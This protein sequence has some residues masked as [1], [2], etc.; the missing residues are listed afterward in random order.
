MFRLSFVF[1]AL[2][3]FALPGAI[4]VEAA[5]GP[6]GV[7]MGQKGDELVFDDD[8]GDGYYVLRSVPRPHSHFESYIVMY[9]EGTG[10][11][12]FRAV[13]IDVATGADGTALKA[14]YE[15]IAGLVSRAY[16]NYDHYEHLADGSSL[17][18]DDNYMKAMAHGEML[19]QASW[20]E[21]SK[22]EL[23]NDITE[24]LLWGKA[25]D[26]ETGYVLLQYR[27]AN[28]AEC[29]DS[30]EAENDGPF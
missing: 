11:C 21:E 22:A 17:D 6:F 25:T 7:A 23:K 28:W 18:G 1:A 27:F 19:L 2:T 29:A 15:L 12:L 26:A 8:A 30:I 4:S 5:D 3:A 13:G 20:D 9:H 16:G 24:V 14:E 10:V